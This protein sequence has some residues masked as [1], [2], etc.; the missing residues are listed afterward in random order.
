[1]ARWK[2]VLVGAIAS[3]MLV[4]AGCANRT[5]ENATTTTDTGTGGAGTEATSE[6]G[7]VEDPAS[8]ESSDPAVTDQNQQAGEPNSWDS[9]TR[10]SEPTRDEEG[11]GTGGSGEGNEGSLIA[12][13][14]EGETSPGSGGGTSGTGGSETGG[15]ETGGGSSTGGGA[16]GGGSGGGGSR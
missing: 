7:Q 2:N 3:G 15:G 16:G 4:F 14:D 9:S 12:P 8:M 11:I 6:T 1:M 10:T 13:E 5:G